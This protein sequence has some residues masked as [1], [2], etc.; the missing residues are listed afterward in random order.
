MNPNIDKLLSDEHSEKYQQVV[1]TNYSFISPFLVAIEE[2]LRWDNTK[3]KR[4]HLAYTMEA[5]KGLIILSQLTTT[6]YIEK[7]PSMRE[8][9]LA[10]QQ[11]SLVITNTIP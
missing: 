3:G 8:A 1:H 11:A 7:T 2:Y 5:I 4:F 10:L 6:R 9:S